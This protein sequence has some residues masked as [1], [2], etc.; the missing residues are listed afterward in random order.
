MPTNSQPT[1]VE[2]TQGESDCGITSGAKQWKPTFWCRIAMASQF[3]ASE[4][5]KG[6][7]H[8]RLIR[9]NQNVRFMRLWWIQPSIVPAGVACCCACRSTVP[10]QSLR[11]GALAS[12]LLF[13]VVLRCLLYNCHMLKTQVKSHSALSM[14]ASASVNKSWTFQYHRPWSRL[15]LNQNASKF[16]MVAE[17]LFN[18]DEHCRSPGT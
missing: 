2:Q 1:H 10:T 17:H 14:H 8:L 6:P 12:V 3:T 5:L 16:L 4:H 18:G 13:L 11:I 15:S 7:E 9:G